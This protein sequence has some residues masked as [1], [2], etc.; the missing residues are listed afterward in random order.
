MLNSKAY[1]AKEE[2]LRLF[3]VHGICEQSKRYS[4]FAKRMNKENITV[5]TYDLRGHGL[6][7]GKRGYIKSFHDHVADLDFIIKKYRNDKVKQV[8]LGHSMGGLIG[9]LYMIKNPEVDAFIATGAPTDFISDV[10]FLRFTGYR[11]FGFLKKKN[12]FGE[13]RLTH[14]KKIEKEYR[15]EPLNLKLFTIRLAGEMF[16]SGVKYLNKNIKNHNKPILIMHGKE[17]I[18]VPYEQSKR[19]FS[20]INHDNKKL[21]LYDNM[22]HEILNEIE[23]EKVIKDIL[24]W[25]NGL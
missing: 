9:H 6:S 5:I 17:D 14:D 20:L 10:K 18:I 12:K 13:N 19:I 1:I 21:I 16:Y 24:E 15:E 8:I 23:K 7:S 25:L 11:W 4:D 3:V 2:K 22:Y